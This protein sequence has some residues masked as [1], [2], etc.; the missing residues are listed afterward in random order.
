MRALE[1]TRDV[2][3]TCHQRDQ[4]CPRRNPWVIF[5]KRRNPTSFQGGSE[6]THEKYPRSQ[7]CAGA[8]QETTPARSPPPQDNA[9]IQK[10]K[11]KSLFF[12]LGTPWALRTCLDVDVTTSKWVLWVRDTRE[13][14]LDAGLPGRRVEP[15]LWRRFP[16]LLGPFSHVGCSRMRIHLE[17]TQSKMWAFTL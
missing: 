16:I 13:E 3:T 2:V 1:K 8:E 17:K 10:W 9:L 5:S 6:S 11:D 4:N 12:P 14:Q 15:G 7:L